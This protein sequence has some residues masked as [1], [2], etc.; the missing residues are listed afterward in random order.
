MSDPFDVPLVALYR[1]L[2]LVSQGDPP[3]GEH[4]PTRCECANTCW[5]GLDANHVPKVEDRAAELSPPW[6][7]SKYR[8]GRTVIVM[9]NLVHYGG[10]DLRANATSGMRHLGW[11]ARQQLR[12]GRRRIFRS[13]AYRGT[14]VWPRAL[15]Y[16]SLWLGA[17][18][19]IVRGPAADHPAEK[20]LVTAL[21]HVAIV[22]HVKC[23]PGTRRSEQPQSMWDTCGGHILAGELAILRPERIIVLGTGDNANALWRHV[24]PGARSNLAEAGMR[25]GR[26]TARVTLWAVE[27]PWGAAVRVLVVPHPAGLGGNARGLIDLARGVFAK[28]A[29]RPTTT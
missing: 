4:L 13:G 2:G 11:L 17:D 5:A 1:G 19:A 16:A 9:E 27:A 22:Q 23:S 10:F 14:D 21:D 8:D 28:N 15:A 20:P 25:V 6:I 7:G 24:L 26:R 3:R 18:P 29:A 12:D